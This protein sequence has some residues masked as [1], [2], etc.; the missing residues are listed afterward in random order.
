MRKIPRLVLWIKFM[1][2]FVLSQWVDPFH[3]DAIVMISR[4]SGF[5]TRFLAD[6]WTSTIQTYLFFLVSVSVSAQ[7]QQISRSS[8]KMHSCHHTLQVIDASE[9]VSSSFLGILNGFIVLFFYLIDEVDNLSI[10][11]CCRAF[12]SQY[13]ILAFLACMLLT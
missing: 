9:G 5:Q 4:K 10:S 7:S 11:V 12:T 3:L 1:H 6:S 2:L 13:S 8:Q